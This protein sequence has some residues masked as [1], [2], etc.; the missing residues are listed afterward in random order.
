MRDSTGTKVETAF[1]LYGYTEENVWY[2][3]SAEMAQMQG[4]SRDSIQ[5]MDVGLCE[6]RDLIGYGH[7]HPIGGCELSPV[8]VNTFLTLPYAMTVIIC[9]GRG[10]GEIGVNFITK[11]ELLRNIR[12]QHETPLPSDSVR[13]QALGS[14]LRSAY[15]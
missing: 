7:T 13:N 5:Q 11:R 2:V 12:R 10:Q 14:F 6:T 1:C 8:D 4:Q 9:P 3:L 15:G